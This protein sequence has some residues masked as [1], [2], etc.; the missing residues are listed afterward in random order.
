MRRVYLIVVSAV[1]DKLNGFL[2]RI[3]RIVRVEQTQRIGILCAGV[4]P[5]M[6]NRTPVGGCSN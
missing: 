4:Q 1:L 6:G 2:R 3:R 5:Y